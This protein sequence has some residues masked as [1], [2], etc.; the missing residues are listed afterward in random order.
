[1]FSSDI[2]LGYPFLKWKKKT[3]TK[4]D[5]TGQVALASLSSLVWKIKTDLLNGC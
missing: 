1:M 4:S 5:Y 3:K 2:I